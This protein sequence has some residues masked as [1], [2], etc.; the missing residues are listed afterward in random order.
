METGPSS[1]AFPSLPGREGIGIALKVGS[2]VR[3]VKEGDRVGLPWLR[4]ACGQCEWCITGWETLCPNAVYGY[5]ANGNF[6]DYALAYVAHIPDRLSD[7]DAAPIL[8]A[9]VTT[10]KALNET[11]VQTGQWVTISDVGGLGQLAV[12]HAVA[13]GLH[14]IAID[15]D[16]EKLLWRNAWVP[17]SQLTYSRMM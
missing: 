6:A 16:S 4:V 13:M 11:E 10:W 1:P 15:I 5:T 7:V 2:A 3:D 14:V 9:G 8:C 12:Q 17:R